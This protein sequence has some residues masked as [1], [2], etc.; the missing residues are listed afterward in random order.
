M[1]WIYLGSVFLHVL[2]AMTWIGGMVVFVAGLMP[3]LRR[4]DEAVRLAVL[5]DFGNRFRRMAWVGFA[6]LVLTGAF[7]LWMRG[8]RPHDFLRPEWRSS[9]FGH[10]VILKLS[11]VLAAMTLSAL[12]ERVV[13]RW[14]AR[15]LG[16][17]TLVAGL[18]IVAVAVM[19]VRVI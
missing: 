3:V 12:H 13:A 8:V 9:P 2:A 15:W 11:L 1:R 6:I 10:L 7:N 14:Q 17:L 4:Q 5:H 16:R 18:L 19:L